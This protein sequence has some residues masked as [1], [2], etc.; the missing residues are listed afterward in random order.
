MVRSRHD[1]RRRVATGRW[2]S[3]QLRYRKAIALAGLG[4]IWCR[5][6]SDESMSR[7]VSILCGLP[8]SAETAATGVDCAA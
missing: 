8:S 3:A 2:Q 5:L 4:V 1:E 6:P 7:R